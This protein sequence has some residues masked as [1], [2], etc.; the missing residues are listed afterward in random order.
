MGR[1]W[2]EVD[3]RA[4]VPTPDMLNTRDV[5]SGMPAGV[6]ASRSPF[7]LG[8]YSVDYARENPMRLYYVSKNVAQDRAKTLP[9]LERYVSPR[10][11][12]L[13]CSYSY[14]T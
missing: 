6:A 11:A 9:P 12:V 1:V 3:E 5:L 10:L 2:N 14:L 4:F 7:S 8:V 13:N